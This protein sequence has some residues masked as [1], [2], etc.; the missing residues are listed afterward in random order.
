MFW[1]SQKDEDI[2]AHEAKEAEMQIQLEEKWQCPDLKCPSKVCWIAKDHGNIHIPL[3]AK[4]FTIWTAGM[5]SKLSIFLSA[6]WDFSESF[7]QMK[8]SHCAT[9]DSPL[10]HPVFDLSSNSHSPLVASHQANS[11]AQR[12][13]FQGPP[14][15]IHNYLNGAPTVANDPATTTAPLPVAAHHCGAAMP[16]SDFAANFGL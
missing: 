1:V 6:F 8:G 11:A 9:L 16:L 3:A 5:V 14:I 2:P 12:G 13:Q 15:H 10:N 7:F 4:E